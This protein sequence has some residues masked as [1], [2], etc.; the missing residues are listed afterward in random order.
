MILASMNIIQGR[1]MARLKQGD[2][3]EVLLDNNKNKG[4][5][6]IFSK[7]ESF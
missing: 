1:K 6:S 3:L 7:I 2:V 4:V 5:Y